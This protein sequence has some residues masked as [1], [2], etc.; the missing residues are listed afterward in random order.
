MYL[1]DCFSYKIENKIIIFGIFSRH[2]QILKKIYSI[3]SNN[4][5]PK[6][7]QSIILEK[8]TTLILHKIFLRMLH[9]TFDTID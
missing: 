7:L 6:I 3:K 5:L 4:I 9:K 2:F 1:L 8:R